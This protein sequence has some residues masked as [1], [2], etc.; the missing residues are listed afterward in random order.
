MPMPWSKVVAEHQFLPQA[1]QFSLCFSFLGSLL[2]SSWTLGLRQASGEEENLFLASA[3]G[4]LF[5]AW[6][7]VAIKEN[8]LLVESHHVK[9]KSSVHLSS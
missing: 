6:M 1:S 9:E 8:S 3:T 2:H 5:L 4:V 7:L